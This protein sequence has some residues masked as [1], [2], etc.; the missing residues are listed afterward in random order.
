MTRRDDVPVTAAAAAVSPLEPPGVLRSADSTLAPPAP[1]PAVNGRR[2]RIDR[3]VPLAAAAAVAV[4][5]A[6]VGV[7]TLIAPAVE[8]A[9]A[10]LGPVTRNGLI[11][12]VGAQSVDDRSGGIPLADLYV[13]RADGEDLRQLTDTAVVPEYSPAFSPDGSLLAFL[14]GHRSCKYCSSESADGTA[15]V[16]VVT[17]TSDTELLVAE[18]PDGYAVNLEWSPDGRAIVVHRDDEAG[19][20][21]SSFDMLERAWTELSAN[22]DTRPAWSPDGRW[23]LVTRE[24]LYAVPASHVRTA[25]I[26]DPSTV[27]GAKRL[28]DDN[29]VEWGATWSPDSRKVMYLSRGVAGGAGVS[30][31]GLDGAAPTMLTNDGF[32]PAWSPDGTRIAYLDA[33]PFVR[34]AEF[35]GAGAEVWIMDPAGESRREIGRS[36]VPPKWSPDSAFIYVFREDGLV[37]I[38]VS[39]DRPDRPLMPR[40]L[41]PSDQDLSWLSALEQKDGAHGRMGGADWQA[42]R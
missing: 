7:N 21:S 40:G 16:V 35:D 24:D 39:G 19:W 17:A 30:V 22:L 13:V 2:R 28:T 37:S 1:P 42:R 5:A 38:D 23:L 33:A 3:R 10:A 34:G 18:V 32:A 27:P 20:S 36:F 41:W 29:W 9:D 25:P 12:F 14:R 26:A 6:A 8:P 31:V 11:A 4:L 15:S